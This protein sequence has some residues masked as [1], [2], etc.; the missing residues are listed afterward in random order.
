M[1]IMKNGSQLPGWAKKGD[2]IR[3]MWRV[4]RGRS[5]F[6]EAKSARTR[7]ELSRE[8]VGKC[9]IRMCRRTQ[10]SGNKKYVLTTADYMW[11]FNYLD[12]LL[13]G[14]L[15][16][17]TYPGARWFGCI[18]SLAVPLGSQSWVLALITPAS[19]SATPKG[20]PNFPC[21]QI[22]KYQLRKR[23]MIRKYR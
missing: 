10:K 7:G 15:Q 4:Q 2:S 8:G 18:G 23:L 3:L 14:L 20:H 5:R 16:N 13:I 21:N 17:W 22:N 1:L 11:P 6:W 19:N 9:F 12:F